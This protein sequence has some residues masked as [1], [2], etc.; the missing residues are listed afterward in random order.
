VGVET[1]GD[2][3]KGRLER[4]FSSSLRWLV[5]VSPLE[6]SPGRVARGSFTPLSE[7]SLSR[8]AKDRGCRRPAVDLRDV[9]W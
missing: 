7:A 3:E 4:P 9:Q 8:F 2:E 5:P 1:T 6:G